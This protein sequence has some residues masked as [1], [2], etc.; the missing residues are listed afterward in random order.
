M[1]KKLFSQRTIPWIGGFKETLAQVAFWI[2]MI[3][4]VQVGA[5]LYYTT[6]RHTVPWFSLWMFVSA[7]LVFIII[8]LVVEYKYIVPS[9][10][11]F[12]G[13]QMFNYE[14]EITERL[15]RIEEKLGIKEEK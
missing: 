4:F 8:G 3:N 9:I 14:S 6:L 10:W 5:I 11:A 2:S 7:T 13:K 15:K 1:L 12:R